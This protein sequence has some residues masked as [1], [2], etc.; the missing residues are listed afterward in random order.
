MT[1]EELVEEKGSEAWWITQFT[2]GLPTI[3]TS[4]KTGVPELHPDFKK[5]ITTTAQRVREETLEE[6]K[7]GIPPVSYFRDMRSTNRNEMR[8]EILAHLSTLNK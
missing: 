7:A 1:H 2:K 3:V 8:D 4:S 5:A 6:V